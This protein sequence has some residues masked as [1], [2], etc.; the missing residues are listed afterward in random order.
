MAQPQSV[1]VTVTASEYRTRPSTSVILA[2][3][4]CLP[5]ERC[6]NGKEF[7][8][9]LPPMALEFLAEIGTDVNGYFFTSG[10]TGQ[11]YQP[12]SIDHACRDLFL[13]RLV[14]P[15]QQLLPGLTT[16]VKSSLDLHTAERAGVQLSPVF[17]GK[18]NSLGNAL[19]DDI[20]ADLG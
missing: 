5:A 14:G 6:K 2:F 16:R 18:G 17:A 1:M 10:R 13:E 8:L 4:S 11:P 20:G 9:P 7:L 15:Q 3:S 12:R 19:V